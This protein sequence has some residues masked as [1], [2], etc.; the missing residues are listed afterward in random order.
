M[1]AGFNTRS[2]LYFYFLFCCIQYPVLLLSPVLLYPISCIITFCSAVSDFLYY[3][4]L[5]CYNQYPVLLPPVLLYPLSIIHLPPDMVYIQYHYLL[6]WYIQ[7]PVLLPPVLLYPVSCIITSCPAISSILYYYLLY[8]VS[9]IITSCPAVSSI[10]SKHVSPSI[11][12]C[13]L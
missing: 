13:F 9:C 12:T 8:P 3:Y 5:S 1:L 7:Y 10:S 4:L 6:S 2:I 11:T